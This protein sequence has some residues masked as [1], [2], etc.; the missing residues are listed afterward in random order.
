MFKI[1]RFISSYLVLSQAFYLS[2]AKSRHR[3]MTL[4]VAA[5]YEDCFFLEDVKNGQTIDFEYQVTSSSSPTGNNDIT[6]RI[7]SPS[8][9]F[10]TIYENKMVTEGSFNGEAEDSGDYRICLDNKVSTWSDKTVWFEVQVEDPEDDYDDDYMDSEEWDAIK[11]NNEDTEKIFE[12]KMDEIK[13]SVHDVRI[14]VGKIRHFQF[15]LGAQ[16]SK[17]THQVGGNLERINFWSVIHLLIMFV[18]G[19]TQVCK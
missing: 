15:M 16:M 3:Q 13:T 1:G 11:A 7:Q 19:F 17:D 10:N 6:V 14:N 2:L 5:G 8:P 4:E 12:M 18:V 9:N